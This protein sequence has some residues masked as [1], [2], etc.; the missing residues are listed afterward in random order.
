MNQVKEKIRNVEEVDAITNKVK[1]QIVS[2]LHY[3]EF[4]RLNLI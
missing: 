4:S 3:L 1:V 2:Q